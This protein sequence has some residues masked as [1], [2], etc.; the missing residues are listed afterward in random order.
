MKGKERKK[1]LGK[2]DRIHIK[3]SPDTPLSVCSQI[4]NQN[5]ASWMDRAFKSTTTSLIQIELPYNKVMKCTADE[6]S[7]RSI[8]D[9]AASGVGPGVGPFSVDPALLKNPFQFPKLP[10]TSDTETKR[11]K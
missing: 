11:G 5:H 7:R 1:E 9:L 10:P 8:Q 6:D 3:P 4:S 2:G